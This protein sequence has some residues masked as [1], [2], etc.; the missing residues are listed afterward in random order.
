MRGWLLAFLLL[1][2]P[3]AAQDAADPAPAD[4][5]KALGFGIG[6]AL[7]WNAK[8]IVPL[9]SVDGAGVVRADQVQTAAARFT[10]EIH[11]FPVKTADFGLGPFVSA[12]VGSSQVIASLGAGVMFGWRTTGSHALGIGV[13]YAVTPNTATLAPEFVPGQPV[14][15]GSDGKPL[16][17]RYQQIDRGSLLLVASFVF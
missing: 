10:A 3:A 4:A 15:V 5:L 9:A 2:A 12:E 17:L 1:A 14:P 8:P 16:P 13:G 11:T 7:R 6:L